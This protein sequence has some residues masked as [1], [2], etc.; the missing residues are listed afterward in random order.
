[1]VDTY[2]T[3]ATVNSEAK[4]KAFVLWFDE[5]G[6]SDIPSVGGKN[7]SLGE[8]IRETDFPRRECSQ[9]ICHHCLCLSLFY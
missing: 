1:M 3:T 2:A 9:W 8:M 7:A 4:E 5:V 6:I